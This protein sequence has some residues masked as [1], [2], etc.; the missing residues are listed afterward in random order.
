LSGGY[1][2]IGP[3]QIKRLPISIPSEKQASRICSL[4]DKLATLLEELDKAGSL[5]DRVKSIQQKISE[6]D[7]E[8]DKAIYD[9]YGLNSEQVELVE[10]S[11]S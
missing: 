8:I 2:G 7:R 10:S 1:M 5:T 11:L 6:V 4:V 3:P 9:V